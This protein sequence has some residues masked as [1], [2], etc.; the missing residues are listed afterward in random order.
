MCSKG[1]T[2]Y[3][4]SYLH[5]GPSQK[6]ADLD[7]DLLSSMVDRRESLPLN[8]IDTLFKLSGSRGAKLALLS[9]VLVYLWR[10]MGRRKYIEG[11]GFA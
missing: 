11:K 9:Q 2:T 3:N 4:L 8:R 1:H 7:L 10:S 6:S 5:S